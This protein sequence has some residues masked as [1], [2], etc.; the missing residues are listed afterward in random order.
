MP[1]HPTVSS[2]FTIQGGCPIESVV[3]GGD[4]VELSFG[5]RPI[6]CGL[7]IDA[8]AL[9]EFLKIGAAALDE[10]DDL[11]AQ[12]DAESQEPGA[13]PGEPPRAATAEPSA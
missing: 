3:L 6:E 11:H 7:T 13:E 9:R 1:T 4:D 2:W 10:M 8:G 5:S 12:E